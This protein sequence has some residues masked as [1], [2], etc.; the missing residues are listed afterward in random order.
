MKQGTVDSN[1]PSPYQ[2]KQPQ[3]RISMPS[4]LP[5]TIPSSPSTYSHNYYGTKINEDNNNNDTTNDDG[6]G[7]DGDDSYSFGSLLGG[8]II[9]KNHYHRHLQ[10]RQINSSGISLKEITVPD[11]DEEDDNDSIIEFNNND[12]GEAEGGEEESSSAL[13][14]NMLNHISINSGLSIRSIDEEKGIGLPMGNGNSGGRRSNTTLALALTS[15]PTTKRRNKLRRSSIES[16]D[17]QHQQQ[18]QQQQRRTS[19]RNVG[20][21]MSLRELIFSN[22]NDNNGDKNDDD[23][24]SGVEDFQNNPTTNKVKITSAEMTLFTK[25]AKQHQVY[26]EQNWQRNSFI[27]SNYDYYCNNFDNTSSSLHYYDCTNN[28]DNDDNDD[29]DEHN[30][31]FADTF[32]DEDTSHSNDGS[33]SGDELNRVVRFVMDIVDDDPELIEHDL[34]NQGTTRKHSSCM[35][36]IF[37]TKSSSPYNNDNDAGV[38]GADLRRLYN[39]GNDDEVNAYDSEEEEDEDS[40]EKKV[41]QGMMYSLGGMAL[42]AA[43]GGVQVFFSAFKNSNDDN[44]GAISQETGGGENTIIQASAENAAH[45]AEMTAEA[46]NASSSSLQSTTFALNSSSSASSSTSASSSASASTSASASA[47][48]STSSATTSATA[49]SATTSATTSA[50]SSSAASASSASASASTASSASAS[51]ASSAGSSAAA[52][53]SVAASSSAGKFVRVFLSAC[54]LFLPGL[55][56]LCFSLISL[57]YKPAA[58]SSSAATSAAAAAASTGASAVAG[59]A[60][61]VAAQ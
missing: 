14:D 45:A 1:L 19:N 10:Q 20:E 57:L 13:T 38:S 48:A 37:N 34:H 8:G 43:I 41:I 7:E 4:T 50:S 31:H 15:I 16:C 26:Q 3:R 61:V 35:L 24:S 29:D 40:P 27:S 44:L 46:T 11:D 36:D 60:T 58:A 12:E 56:C 33:G 55:F 18:Q 53:S 54:L 42:V 32:Q 30:E 21:M 49:S 47:S 5:P 28:D 39:D 6:D 17:H 22:G 51:A 23:G 9:R 2:K 25:H 59:Q 52:S